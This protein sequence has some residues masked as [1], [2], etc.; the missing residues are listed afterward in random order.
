MRTLVVLTVLASLAVVASPAA[1]ADQEPIPSVTT[2]SASASRLTGA[3][4]TV[5]ERPRILGSAR[6]GRT[7][8]AEPPRWSVKPTSVRYQWLREGRVVD[9]GRRHAVRVADVGAHLRVQ[10]TARR[11][12]FQSASVR[13]PQVVGRHRVPL[14]HT[15]RYSVTTRGRVTADL[16]GFRRLAQETL[17]DP[18]GWRGAGIGF[19]RVARGGAF[20]MVLSQAALLP[21]FGYPCSSMWSCR[22]GDNVIINQDR[23]LGASPRWKATGGTLRDYRHM[24]VNHETGH[25]LGH[26]HR[27]CSGSGRLA[28]VMM[29]QSKGLHGCRPNPWPTAAERF[30]PR[31]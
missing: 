17:D 19:R 11:A 13:S 2:T 12:G 28:P 29:Q 7:L 25:W 23:W 27:Y 30:A 31:F 22:V 4:L 5:V 24:V 21:S 1:H 26:G 10:V 18:R 9:R 6:F 20:R 15:V 16:S 8:R 14:R 3:I